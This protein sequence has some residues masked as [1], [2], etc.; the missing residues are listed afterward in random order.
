MS[1]KVHFP[2]SHVNYFPGYL[3]AWWKSNE[4]PSTKI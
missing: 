1:V 4:S 3:E 2:Q